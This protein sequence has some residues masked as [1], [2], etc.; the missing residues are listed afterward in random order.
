MKKVLSL[1]PSREGRRFE[2]PIKERWF[3]DESAN[4]SPALQPN[5]CVYCSNRSSN[6]WAVP[7]SQVDVR[8][9]PPAT[10]NR[11]LQMMVSVRL[12]QRPLLPVECIPNSPS[13]H[14]ANVVIDIPLLVNILMQKLRRAGW[15]SAIETVPSAGRC[16][17][18][19]DWPGRERA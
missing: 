19:L 13:A 5:Y 8:L 16:H 18:L 14:C 12:P 10:V 9:V 15:E 11:I 3:L 1:E 6:V 2:W 17:K 4:I 7:G